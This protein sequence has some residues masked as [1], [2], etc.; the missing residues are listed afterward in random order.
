MFDFRLY[1][2]IQSTDLSVD[3]IS[4]RVSKQYSFELC[5]IGFSKI[6]EIFMINSMTH[7]GL[8]LSCL[9]TLISIR[10]FT[11]NMSM[12]VH[13]GSNVYTLERTYILLKYILCEQSE[14]HTHSWEG[15]LNYYPAFL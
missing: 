5:G 8:E 12:S 4:I 6:Y 7:F 1:N 11:L 2:Q 13:W 15:S 3:G 9:F 10:A 14:Y